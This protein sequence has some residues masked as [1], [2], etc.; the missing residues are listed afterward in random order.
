MRLAT[1]LRTLEARIRPEDKLPGLL[2][3]FEDEPGI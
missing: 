3:V 1:R 2:I